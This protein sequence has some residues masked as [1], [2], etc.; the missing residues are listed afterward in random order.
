[1]TWPVEKKI[2]VK[3]S[4]CPVQ[5]LQKKP[6]AASPF[7]KNVPA[8]HSLDRQQILYSTDDELAKTILNSVLAFSRLCQRKID[9]ED[10]EI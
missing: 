5:L 9:L 6:P 8:P 3:K 2:I 10:E 4:A 7:P 1:M